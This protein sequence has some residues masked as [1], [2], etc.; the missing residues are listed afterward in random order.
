MEKLIEEQNEIIAEACK[1]GWSDKLEIRF[2]ELGR[3]ETLLLNQKQ[4][5]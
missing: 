3:Q 2:I 4:Y 1:T 5:A